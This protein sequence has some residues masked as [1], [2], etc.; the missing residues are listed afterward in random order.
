MWWQATP[1]LKA[2]EAWH[3]TLPVH[4]DIDVHGAKLHPNFFALRAET[5][6]TTARP[7]LFDQWPLHPSQASNGPIS[8]YMLCIHMLG[9]LTYESFP[10]QVSSFIPN[11]HSLSPVSHF[12]FFQIYIYIYI[13]ILRT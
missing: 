3:L 1:L 8:R 7:L 2:R 13:Y 12:R 4:T 10:L 5:L 6:S 9:I 11:V